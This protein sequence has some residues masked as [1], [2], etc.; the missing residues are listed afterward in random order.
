MGGK[1]LTPFP[2]NLP[3]DKSVMMASS[4]LF[5]S[6]VSTCQSVRCYVPIDKLR[7]LPNPFILQL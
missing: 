7:A 3:L 1:G 2:K 5:L 4:I 6:V